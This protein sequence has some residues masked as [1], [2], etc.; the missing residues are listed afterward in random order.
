MS[1]SQNKVR[2]DVVGHPVAT[3]ARRQK[4][5]ALFWG[6]GSEN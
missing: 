6:M 2:I 4:W 3:R 1:R 5:G